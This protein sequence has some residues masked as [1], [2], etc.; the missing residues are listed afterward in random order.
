MSR[1]KR[2]ELSQRNNQKQ[3]DKKKKNMIPHNTSTPTTVRSDTE[4]RHLESDIEGMGRLKVTEEWERK[5]TSASLSWTGPKLQRAQWRELQA[6]LRAV[7]ERDHSEAQVRLFCNQRLNAWKV[8]AFPQEARTGMSAREIDNEESRIQRA[9]FRDSEGWSPM[10]TVHSHCGGTAFQ[11]GTDMNNERHIDGL[12]ITL[13]KVDKNEFD[14][15]GRFSI[16]GRMLDIVDWSAFWQ[17]PD[18]V[19]ELGLPPEVRSKIALH[20]MC[21]GPEADQTFPDEWLNNVIEIKT[22]TPTYQKEWSFRGGKDYIRSGPTGGE[23]YNSHYG[24]FIGGYGV[25]DMGGKIVGANAEDEGEDLTKG[26]TKFSNVGQM[27]LIL[28]LLKVCGRWK[29]HRQDMCDFIK[30]EGKFAEIELLTLFC[31]AYNCH[32]DD[33]IEGVQ[34]HEIADGKKPQT[35]ITDLGDIQ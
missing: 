10:G 16:L 35:N 15:H 7:N 27:D 1:K 3:P 8:H 26:L 9:R 29:I 13:G 19:L 23:V 17:L 32:I 18:G 11:S 33:L 31:R 20:D 2:K 14:I 24:G 22:V 12:H 34:W 21:K 25:S 30:N 4:E 6:F 5:K 28:K